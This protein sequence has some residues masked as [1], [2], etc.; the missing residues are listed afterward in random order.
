MRALW[1]IP[2][3]DSAPGRGMDLRLQAEAS[4]FLG[5]ERL[6]ILFRGQPPS[7]LI[8]RVCLPAIDLPAGDPTPVG[9]AA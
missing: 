9:P 7:P 4:F 2:T 6:T 8:L 3:S 1:G 5:G